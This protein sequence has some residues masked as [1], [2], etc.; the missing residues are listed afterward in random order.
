MT[1]GAPM[2]APF[3]SHRAHTLTEA[4]TRYV[5]TFVSWLGSASIEVKDRLVAVML[6]NQ[7]LSS[8]KSTRRR[9]RGVSRGSNFRTIVVR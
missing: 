6:P 4:E 2:G 9:I 3:P 7:S 1:G 8:A 5:A